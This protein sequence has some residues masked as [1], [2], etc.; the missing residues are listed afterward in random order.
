MKEKLCQHS[1]KNV[2]DCGRGKHIG[3]IGKR[4]GSQVTNEEQQ[5]ENNAGG[6][7][8]REDGVDGTA[9]VADGQGTDFFH[10]AREHDIAARAKYHHATQSGLLAQIHRLMIS[11]AGGFGY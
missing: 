10:A 4:K 5:Q 11:G 2:T 6:N 7:P 3:E 9:E 1:H 8:R